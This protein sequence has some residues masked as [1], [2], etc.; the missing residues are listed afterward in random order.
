M[1]NIIK[2]LQTTPDQT[3]GFASGLDPPRTRPNN[4]IPIYLPIIVI[5]KSDAAVARVLNKIQV[6]PG[7]ESLIHSSSSLYN[8]AMVDQAVS[9]QNLASLNST[10]TDQKILIC[11]TKLWSSISVEDDSFDRANL[12]FLDSQ[13]LTLNLRGECSWLDL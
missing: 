12:I 4:L 3:S 10:K 6:T 2:S 8:M 13:V 7:A 9:Y 11:V 1:H 5:L